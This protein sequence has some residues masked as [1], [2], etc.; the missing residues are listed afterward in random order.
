MGVLLYIRWFEIVTASVR[1][2]DG[3]NR[4][5]SWRHGVSCSHPAGTITDHT[6]QTIQ[7]T[8]VR[9]A[10]RG[11]CLSCQRGVVGVTDVPQGI[12]TARVKDVLM[13]ELM[14]YFGKVAAA[15]A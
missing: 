7:G 1:R 12:D 2:L 5:N 11:S 10:W 8:E 15:P 4:P 6:V 14:T 3:A 13:N 9:Y